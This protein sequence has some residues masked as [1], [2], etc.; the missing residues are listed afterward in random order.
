M[1]STDRR[2][3]SMPRTFFRLGLYRTRLIDR[4]SLIKSVKL[5]AAGTF[6]VLSDIVTLMLLLPRLS[7]FEF[8]SCSPISGGTQCVESYNTAYD[9]VFLLSAFGIILLFLGRF[10]K[11]FIL[12]PLFI[13]GL[14]WQNGVLRAWPLAI[15]T[16]NGALSRPGST[17]RRAEHPDV[18]EIPV[19][20]L[21]PS[22]SQ[23]LTKIRL[24]TKCSGNG[25]AE[26]RQASR[27]G[28]RRTRTI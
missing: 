6:L 17:L 16:C 18:R 24:A 21:S 8:L 5:A 28:P 7:P 10:G 19:N 22:L 11:S 12:K 2:Q 20:L 13:L 9:F 1:W 15:F 14:I 27:R 3:R 25:M 23:P 4:I 26:I